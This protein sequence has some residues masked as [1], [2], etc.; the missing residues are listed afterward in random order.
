VAY[1]LVFLENC[2]LDRILQEDLRDAVICTEDT[3]RKT[4]TAL[5]VRPRSEQGLQN[6]LL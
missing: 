4:V 1:L 5:D 6:A 2:V 3:K